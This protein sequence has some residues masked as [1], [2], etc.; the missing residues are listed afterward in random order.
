MRPITCATATATAVAG[1]ALL[2]AV[3]SAAAQRPHMSYAHADAIAFS[4]SGPKPKHSTA[5]WT[6]ALR[7]GRLDED[8]A[9]GFV[10]LDPRARLHA[11]PS[12]LQDGQ[13][14]VVTWSGIP[15][16]HPKDKIALS[17]GPQANA[18]DFLDL[19]KIDAS[20]TPD[21][22]RFPS[23]YMMRCNYVVSYLNYVADLN[24]H[25]EIARLEVKMVESVNAPKHGHIAFT[26]RIDEMAVM[27]NSASNRTPQVQFGTTPENLT[28][29]ASG[30]STTYHASDMCHQP[31]TTVSQTFFRDPGFMHKVTL[32][33]L[34]SS[35]RYFYRFG[36]DQDGWSAVYSF[37]SRP[38][39]KAKAAKFIAYADMDVQDAP[40]ST[41]TA[42][43][44]YQ[45]V[46][47]RGYDNFLLHF[48]D[49][50]YA[51]G[52]A[53]R[54]DQFFHIIEPYA[55]RVPYMIS[56]GNHEYDYMSG[57]EGH[58]PSGGV[59]H[60][61]RMAFHPWWANY[62]EDSSGECSVPMYHRWHAPD[63]GNGIYWYSF[64]YGGIHVI[65]MSSE[66]DWTQGSPQYKWIEAD[67]ANV[68][69][70]KTP[71]IVLTAHR[72]MYTTQLGEAA[73]LL[74]SVHFRKH[75]EDLLWKY[76]VNLVLVGHQHSYERSCAVRGGKCTSDGI[77]PV[78]IVVGSAGAGLETR[79]FSRDLGEWSVSHVN[80]W[81]YLRVD[82]TEHEMHLEFVLNRNGVVYD[83]VTL[84]PW[85]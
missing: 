81:G 56:I 80:D 35:T 82:A 50:S 85:H 10:A 55:T 8:F 28:E 16:P 77:G 18:R 68:D 36:N 39:D 60:D 38:D 15:S 79:G 23:L 31:A 43:R 5:V 75:M 65:Q 42:E 54:W 78:H 34:T 52:Q 57:G 17:C 1:L 14:L 71:W 2:F 3:D 59:G 6:P 27:F 20:S 73:D 76:K 47:S 45:D 58:D 37:M 84:T 51:R 64:D 25:R 72:M 69:R 4:E 29:V 40:A 11:S 24:D 13:D 63:N 19:V 44:V 7:W 70:S 48:G 62:G 9:G 26:G 49:V 74:V 67:L 22:V 53:F 41:S 32:K 61:G 66:H 33:G 12:Q 46:I 30:Q 83:E 21:S